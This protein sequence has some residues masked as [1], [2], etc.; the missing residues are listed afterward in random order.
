[1][2]RFPW[3]CESGD[4]ALR[5][6]TAAVDRFALDF[7]RGARIL[8]LGCAETDWLERMRDLRMDYELV[9]VDARQEQRRDDGFLLIQGDACNQGLFPAR[10]FDAIVMLGALEHFGLGFYGDPVHELGDRWTMDNVAF[11]LKPNGFVY[12]DVPCNPTYYVTENRHF[13]VYSPGAIGYRL[14]VPG[15]VETHRGYS[16]GDDH[17]DTWIAAPTEHKVP[18]HYCAVVAE[19]ADR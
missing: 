14:I 6:F 19:K 2:K 12:F 13:R 10:S 8:E 4:P 11:W 18:Y 15:L 17:P 16:S 3:T 5:L 1:M 9:G 7:P